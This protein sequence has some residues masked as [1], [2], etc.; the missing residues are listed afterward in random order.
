MPI[1]PE[2]VQLMSKNGYFHWIQPIYKNIDYVIDIFFNY[3]IKKWSINDE[4]LLILIKI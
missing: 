2:I 3:I 4:I 1:N